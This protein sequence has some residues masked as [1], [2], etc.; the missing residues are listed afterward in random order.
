MA[1]LYCTSNVISHEKVWYFYS[2]TS[3]SMRAANGY[4]IK[5]TSQKQTTT[6]SQILK[7][8]VQSQLLTRDRHAW[9]A[10]N[11]SR[12][13]DAKT[14]ETTLQICTFFPRNCFVNAWKCQWIQNR[15]LNFNTRQKLRLTSSLQR[16]ANPVLRSGLSAFLTNET[17]NNRNRFI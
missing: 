3:R 12:E 4:K 7:I 14:K 1:T 5:Q 16:Q 10:V 6:A 11:C 15:A 17:V 8:T 9:C 2:S 13:E